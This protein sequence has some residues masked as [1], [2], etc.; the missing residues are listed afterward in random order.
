MLTVVGAVTCWLLARYALLLY[1]GPWTVLVLFY[2]LY[3]LPSVLSGCR[4][5]RCMYVRHVTLL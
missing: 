2:C 4:G 1:A 3:C 5:G